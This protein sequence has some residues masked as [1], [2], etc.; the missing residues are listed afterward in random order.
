MNMVQEEIRKNPKVTTQELWERAKKL[1]RSIASLNARQF[2][3]RY[4][5]QVKR[6][7]APR[8]GRGGRPRKPRVAATP[9]TDRAGV[10]SVLVQFAKDVAAAEGKAQMIEVIGGVDKYVER[11]LKAAGSA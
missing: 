11:V 9:T 7:M 3:A 8:R 5:L 1:D 10:R 4:P 2:N 6:S